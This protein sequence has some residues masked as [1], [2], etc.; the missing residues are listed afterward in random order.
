MKIDKALIESVARNA[1]ITLSEKEKERF[2]KEFAEILDAFSIVAQAPASDVASV[3][4][5]P[6]VDVTRAD[7]PTACLSQDEALSTTQL[8]KDGYFKGPKVL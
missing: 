5:T 7:T 8:K 6:V 3:H 2:V 1:R 4:P